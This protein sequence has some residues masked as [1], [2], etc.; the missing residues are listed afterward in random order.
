[1]TG[2][3]IQ[4]ELPGVKEVHAVDAAGVHPLLLAVGSERYTP[5][6]PTQQPAELLTQANLILGKGQLSLAKYLWIAADESNQLTAKHIETYLQFIL[7]RVDWQRDIHFYTRTSIDTLDYSGEGLNSGSKMVIAACGSQ[8]RELAVDIPERLR[9]LDGIRDI[10]LVLPGVLAIQT[11]AFVSTEEMHA[12]ITTWEKQLSPT[13]TALM[14]F[15]LWVICDDAAFVSASLNHFLWV[16]F[17]RSN[18]SHDVHGL[19]SFTEHK[20][21]GCRGPLVIDA[22]SKPHHAPRLEKDPE[23]EKRIDRFFKPGAVLEKWA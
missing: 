4:H 8:Q 9:S 23:I 10:R 6:A 5:Y 22:R 20:H 14:A 16:S 2:E 13:D 17:T 1:M 11:Q 19:Y 18:P 21:W 15:P 12:Q 7:Q 3:A